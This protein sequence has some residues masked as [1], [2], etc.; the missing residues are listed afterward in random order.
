MES[1][2]K[3]AV[4]ELLTEWQAKSA[5][6]TEEESQGDPM[7]IVPGGEICAASGGALLLARAMAR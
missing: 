6:S 2:T 5:G 7:R 3:G 4:S 1:K